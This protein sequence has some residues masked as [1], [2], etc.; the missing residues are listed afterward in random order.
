VWD[1]HESEESIYDQYLLGGK[2]D[3]AY[4][5]ARDT[6]ALKPHSL[7][8]KALLAFSLLILGLKESALENAEEVIEVNPYNEWALAVIFA[9]SNDEEIEENEV[10]FPFNGFRL[11]DIWYYRFDCLGLRDVARRHWGFIA[12]FGPQEDKRHILEDVF[13]VKR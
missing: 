5:W 11:G 7:E 9:C 6:F 8:L 12:R 2:T 13:N 4:A 10:F 1:E 3:K